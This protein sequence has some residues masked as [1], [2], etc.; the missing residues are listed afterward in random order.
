[1]K[2]THDIKDR[3]AALKGLA[4]KH[5]FRQQGCITLPGNDHVDNMAAQNLPYYT[6]NDLPC[7]LC[8]L[9]HLNNQGAQLIL[10]MAIILEPHYEDLLIFF[11]REH[12]EASQKQDHHSGK[13]IS[14]KCIHKYLEVT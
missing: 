14:F 1:M 10:G 9:F 7:L 13:H 12:I 2:S 4:Q 5:I 3:N 6:F 8:L 11:K